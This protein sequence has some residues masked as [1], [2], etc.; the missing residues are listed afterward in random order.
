MRPRVV[1]ARR[2]LSSGCR[3]EVIVLRSKYDLASRRQRS[4]TCCETQRQWSQSSP[5]DSENSTTDCL[6]GRLGCIVV[7]RSEKIERQMDCDGFTLLVHGERMTMEDVG[8]AEADGRKA[9]LRR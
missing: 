8:P 4:A 3:P 1:M 6:F 2:A 9:A 5:W 7:I